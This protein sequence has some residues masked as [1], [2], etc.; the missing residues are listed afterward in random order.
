MSN[1]SDFYGDTLFETA[2][3][4]PVDRVNLAGR[5]QTSLLHLVYYLI[6][7]QDG[8]TFLRA[9][10]VGLPNPA[11]PGTNHTDVTI[12]AALRAKFLSY[13]VSGTAQDAMIG[14]HFA[15]NAWVAAHRANDLVAR[16]QAEATFK[17]QMSAITW[18]LWDEGTGPLFP[19]PW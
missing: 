14:V 19:L 3:S 11:Q 2:G 4:A 5:Y 16:D 18:A 15:G 10:K 8:R 7:D 9:L 17:Q 6:Y 12:R 13:G 1:I